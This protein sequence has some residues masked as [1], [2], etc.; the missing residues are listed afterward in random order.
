MKTLI[1]SNGSKWAGQ[2]PDS[3]EDLI[4]VLAKHDLDLRR[5][6]A[7]GFI[8]F[9]DSNGYGNR[10]YEQHSVKIIGNFVGV[11]HVF[12]IEGVYENLRPLINAIEENIGR[13]CDRIEKEGAK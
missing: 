12:D 5:F 1:N 7:H 6:A 4:K 8:A 9:T 2:E 11:S 13:Q 10:D 3:V